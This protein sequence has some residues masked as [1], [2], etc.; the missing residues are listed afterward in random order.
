MNLK[1]ELIGTGLNQVESY[2]HLIRTSVQDGS[3]TVLGNPKKDILEEVG[4]ARTKAHE[5]ASKQWQAAELAITGIVK[6]F[7]SSIAPEESTLKEDFINSFAAGMSRQEL[8]FQRLLSTEMAEETQK[9]LSETERVELVE[10]MFDE[11]VGFNQVMSGK[12]ISKNIL[13]RNPF[14]RFSL[15]DVEMELVKY[16]DILPENMIKKIIEDNLR[17][18]E[19]LRSIELAYFDLVEHFPDADAYYL[20]VLAHR[21][22]DRCVEEAERRFDIADKLLEGPTKLPSQIVYNIAVT[23]KDPEASIRV[24]IKTTGEILQSFPDMPVSVAQRVAFSQPRNALTFAC[25]LE[26]AIEK[27]VPQYDGLP[28]DAIY[29]LALSWGIGNIEGTVAKVMDEVDEFHAKFP[30]VARKRLIRAAFGNPKD[31]VTRMQAHINSL[32]AKTIS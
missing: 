8:V 22:T 18:G 1:N 13:M 32:S 9:T 31:A 29:Y 28:R 17:P 27:I 3:V 11:Y 5:Y 16:N 7:G 4:Q 6:I 26:E 23:H 19:R 10:R 15:E 25:R 12:K 14:I 2:I 24:L 21:Y 30:K 20:K